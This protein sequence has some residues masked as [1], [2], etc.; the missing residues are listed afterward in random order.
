MDPQH[1][2]AG[3]AIDGHGHR[4]VS[5]CDRDRQAV[6]ADLLRLLDSHLRARVGVLHVADSR[7]A[8]TVDEPAHRRDFGHLGPAAAGLAV[9]A[10][11]Y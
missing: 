6:D 7:L 8:V 9:H 10:L 5:G 4:R 11:Q 2:M 1:R 3:L